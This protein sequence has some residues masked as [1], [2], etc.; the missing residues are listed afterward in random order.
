MTEGFWQSQARGTY[1]AEYCLVR[2]TIDCS[3]R[4]ADAVILTDEPHCRGLKQNFPSLEGHNVTVVQTK[5]RRMGMY[6]MG[7]AVFSARLV[8][9]QG[10]LSVRSILLCHESD[11]ALLPFLKPFPE[12]EVWLS[13]MQNPEICRRVAA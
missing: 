4:L 11:S 2:R 9:R 13:D 12:V 7:Q 10:A 5:P 1:L 6:L 3:V 8:M